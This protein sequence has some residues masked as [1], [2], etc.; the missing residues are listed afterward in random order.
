MNQQEKDRYGRF[1]HKSDDYRRVR[2]I[3][4]TDEA[5]EKLGEIAEKL[6]ITRA[7]LIEEWMEDKSSNGINEEKIKAVIEE[8]LH[9]PEVTRKGKDK[10]AV[11]RGFEALLNRLFSE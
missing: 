4:V 10:S 1:L 5:W 2:S 11:R 3:R 9:D 6:S 8:I 7:D